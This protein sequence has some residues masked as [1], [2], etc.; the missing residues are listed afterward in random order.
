MILW[1]EEAMQRNLGVPVNSQ[2]FHVTFSSESVCIQKALCHG[3]DFPTTSEHFL[4]TSFSRTD[5]FL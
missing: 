5:V 4:M 1:D 2:M 3:T